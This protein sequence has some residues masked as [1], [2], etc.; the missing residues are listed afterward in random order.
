MKPALYSYWR[1]SCSY[2]VRIALNVKQIDYEYR[3]VHL[4]KEGGQQLKET[5]AAGVNPMREVPCLALDGHNITQSQGEH[6]TLTFFLT[7]C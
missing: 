6:I 2:R 1:S 5:F 4:L 7:Q 3:A